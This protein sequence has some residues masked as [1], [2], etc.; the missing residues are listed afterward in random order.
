[1]MEFDVNIDPQGVENSE[2]INNTYLYPNPSEDGECVLFVMN[3]CKVS[4]TDITGKVVKEFVAIPNFA[5]QFS[6]KE[7]GVYLVNAEGEVLKLI[8]K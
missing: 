2:A 6:I 7:K 4:I 5:N 1:G 8:V 3:R